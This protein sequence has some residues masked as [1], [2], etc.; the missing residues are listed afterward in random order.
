[1]F[2]Y[3]SP[4][5]P[6]LH[7][8]AAGWRRLR[9]PCF[10]GTVAWIGRRSIVSTRIGPAE[11]QDQLQLSA[12]SRES[13]RD[14]CGTVRPDHAGPLSPTRPSFSLSKVCPAWSTPAIPRIRRRHLPGVSARRGEGLLQVFLTAV[15][16]L[17]LS[18]GESSLFAQPAPGSPTASRQTSDPLLAGFSRWDADFDGVL[19]CQEW[20]RYAE[21][22]FMRSDRNGD[23]M[24]DR[25]EFTILGK[26][27][28]RT[29][30][31]LGE[32]RSRV[33]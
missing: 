32:A 28:S 6:I 19:T 10:L 24:L 16:F 21:Q 26:V 31:E 4:A 3:R 20:K 9:H 30:L 11:R 18:G 23:G 29:W 13:E 1:M 17:T 12:A 25:E 15:L 14:G 22:L 7:R 5:R 27:P 33:T 2:C 8:D